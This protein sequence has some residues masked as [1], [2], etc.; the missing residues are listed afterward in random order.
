[1]SYGTV[2]VPLADW[3]AAFIAHIVRR[4]TDAGWDEGHALDAAVNEFEGLEDVDTSTDPAG[5]ADESL[6][7]W[8]DDGDEEG[9]TPP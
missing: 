1:M 3:R 7:Y 2:P 6:S 4:L 5:E 8:S 9:L